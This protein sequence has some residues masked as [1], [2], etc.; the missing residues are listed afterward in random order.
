MDSSLVMFIWFLLPLI[1]L[2]ASC[3]LLV[4]AFASG[5]VG[6]RVKHKRW[7]A[8]AFGIF[9]LTGSACWIWF[10]LSLGR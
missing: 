10:F 8:W 7:L 4:L 5:F 2:P 1:A 9:A 6:L 3:V